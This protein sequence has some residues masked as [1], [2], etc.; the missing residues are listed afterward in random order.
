M[1][2]RK[3]VEDFCK[4][5]TVCAKFHRGKP[6]KQSYLKSLDCGAVNE[7][8]HLDLSGPY[9][10]SNGYRYICICVDAFSRYLVAVPIR[11]K[12]ALSV[13][14]VLV[15]DVISR[16]G[17]F[18][19]LQTDNGKEFQNEIITHL[20]QLLRIDQ[21]RITSYRPS[22]NGRCEII[23]KTLH[24]LMGRVVA[25]NQRDWSTWLPFCALAYNTTRHESTGQSP[26]RLMYGREVLIPL[27]LLLGGK[28]LPEEVDYCEYVEQ[29]D[30]QMRDMFEVVQDHQDKQVERMKRYYN[31]G[32]KPKT[33][34]PNDLVYY[35]Y[36]R[37]YVGRTPKWNRVYADV[38][39]VEKRI[40]DAV[41]VIRKSP[42]SRQVVANVDKLKSYVGETPAC[43]KRRIMEGQDVNGRTGRVDQP[44]HQTTRG[45]EAQPSLS[46][47]PPPLPR[48]AQPS[49]S[50]VSP[51]PGAGPLPPPLP[52]SV[53]QP[54]GRSVTQSS[55]SGSPPMTGAGTPPPPPPLP[56]PL[57]LSAHQSTRRSVAQP[58]LSGVSPLPGAGRLSPSPLQLPVYQPTRCGETQPSLSGAP[59]L[60]GAGTLSL[61][62]P[63]P[64]YQ[65][66]R[67][68]VAQPS[69]S[70]TLSPLPPLPRWRNRR[71]PARPRWP[72]PAR[73]H[74][75]RRCRVRRNRRCP[76]HRR[77]CRR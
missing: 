29:V 76:A 20:C 44:G 69:L 68:S 42:N 3:Y 43:W 30:R 61:S 34:Q 28:P 52:L 25:D 26:Y 65:Q 27:D 58:S 4:R 16:F 40:N 57:P 38:Y 11:D 72:V 53:H 36:P 55:L 73:R 19:S 18:Q 77:R 64:A 60:P 74:R 32:V 71:C 9:P 59:P 63:L 6:P 15:R 70:G 17:C 21:L 51:M 49:L 5:C 46:G 14:K 1:R 12:S 23:N 66:T 54:T 62:S 48:L 41:Y 24:A 47:T 75:C 10:A 37:K 50:G 2:W 8:W 35:Y 39:L 22:G 33:F 13:A 67:R 56:P 31:V 7:R 45:G